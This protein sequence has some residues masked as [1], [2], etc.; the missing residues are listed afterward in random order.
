VA[1]VEAAGLVTAV[2]ADLAP[3]EEG[4]RAAEEVEAVRTEAELL[5]D[6]VEAADTGFAAEDNALLATEAEPETPVPTEVL[7]EASV[8][9]AAAAEDD[10]GP[11]ASLASA[12]DPASLS[13]LNFLRS[14]MEA[15]IVAD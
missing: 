3:E 15:T 8:L 1:A 5:D 10:D 14:L 2:T 13:S 6:R 12:L 11:A 7:R 4:G 9:E